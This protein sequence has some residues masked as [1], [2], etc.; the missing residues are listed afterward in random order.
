MSNKTTL[1]ALLGV[2]MVMSLSSTAYAANFQTTSLPQAQLISADSK[3]TNGSCGSNGGCGSQTNGSSQ[4][5]ANNGNN[6][7]D[8][9]NNNSS[10]MTKKE[11]NAKQ[12]ADDLAADQR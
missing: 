4:Q 7:T 11:Q 9:N 10:D 12:F 5:G 8:N 6:T 1:G 2:G 3:N